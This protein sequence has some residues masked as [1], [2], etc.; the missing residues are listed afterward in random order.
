MHSV[1]DMVV[2]LDRDTT[3]GDDM[4]NELAEVIGKTG[5]IYDQGLEFNVTV[6]D[7]KQSWGRTRYLVV[8]VSGS[9]ERWDENVT[10]DA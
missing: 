7:A 9:G 1:Y 3:K 6:K 8:P 4:V 2:P 5:H 10:I